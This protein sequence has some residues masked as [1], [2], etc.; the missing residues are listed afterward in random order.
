MAGDWIKMRADLFTH[1]KVVRM[2]SA[3][4]ADTLRTVGG[5]M[6][7]WCLFDAH[8]SDG[9]LQGYTP[10]TLDAHIRWDGFS[11][12]M[13]AVGW[14]DADGDSLV[15]PRFDIHNGQ[16]AKRRAQDA[17][18][19]REV[20]KMSAEEED[21]KRTREEKRREEKKN[22][23]NPRK[24]GT[25]T[26]FSPTFEEAW[27]E[28]P[29]RDGG[30]SKMGAWKAWKARLEA[31]CNEMEMLE[32][33]KRYAANIRRLKKEGSTFVKM[34]A[35]FYGPSIHFRD[36]YAPPINGTDRPFQGHQ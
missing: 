7:V 36:T 5:L 4:R 24:R 12:A 22:P 23:P 34:A 26:D 9:K 16:S 15:L 11:A 32:G 1:P 33:T 19:K 2:S 13:K 21:E 35:T 30:N 17:D 6:S 28:Y 27:A 10:E 14:L 25:V 29:A 18:R 3:L 31:G 20:R 8:S